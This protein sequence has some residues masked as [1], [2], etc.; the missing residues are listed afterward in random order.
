ML[1]AQAPGLHASPTAWQN[2][3]AAS[4]YPVNSYATSASV[5]AQVPTGQVPG[6]NPTMQAGGPGYASAPGTFPG[7]TYPTPPVPA[8]ATS[9][10]PVGSS[11]LSQGS[12]ISPG[13]ASMAMTHPGFPMN[14]RPGGASPPGQPPY[15]GR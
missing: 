9:T 2:P 1:A 4:M 10:G 13:M 5:A 12:P 15:Y 11:P 3:Q 6:W 7:P 14:M 8:Y